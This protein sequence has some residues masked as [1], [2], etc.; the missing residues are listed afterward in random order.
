MPL[1][2]HY[3]LK[4]EG[5]DKKLTTMAQQKMAECSNISQNTKLEG[6]V[7]QAQNFAID[8]WNVAKA[9]VDIVD[10]TKE[11]EILLVRHTQGVLNSYF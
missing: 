2:Y 8:C 3:R 5:L 9:A 1:L 6:Y 4:S 11:I 7:Q 10:R